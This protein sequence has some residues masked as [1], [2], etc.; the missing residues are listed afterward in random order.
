MAPMLFA[1]AAINNE[2]IQVFNHG[3]QK[4]DFTHVCGY[5]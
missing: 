2:K 3:N 5:C 1:K 4:R